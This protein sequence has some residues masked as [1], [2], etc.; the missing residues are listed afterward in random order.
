MALATSRWP[1]A[2]KMSTI[3]VASGKCS[4]VKFQIH[5]APSPRTTRRAALVEAAPLGLA[6]DAPCEGRRLG[7]GIAGGDGFEALSPSRRHARGGRVCQGLRLLRGS[8]RFGL[9]ATAV[10]LALARWHAG[11]VEAEMT[12]G[13]SQGS[14]SAFVPGDLAPASVAFDRLGGDARPA[15]FSATIGAREAG[16]RRCQS[17]RSAA[18]DKK[19]CSM[20]SASRGLKPW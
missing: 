16:P 13:A 2:W 7:V 14:G 6:Q 12:V 3:W 10:D 9:L 11:A 18:G 17:W 5:G 8:W 15:I 20:P 1:L 4:S 19:V